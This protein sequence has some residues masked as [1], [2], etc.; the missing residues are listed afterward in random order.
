MQKETILV[1]EKIRY[2]SEW[3][4]YSIFNFPHIL[5]KQIPGCGFTEYCITNNEDVILCSPRKILLQNKYDQ[6]KDEVFLVVNEYEKEVG[7]DK[8]LTK[9]PKYRGNRFD[10]LDKPDPEK[11]KKEEGDKKSFF[12]SLTYKIS[13]YIKACRLNDRPIKILVT[14]DS[15]RIVKDIIRHQDSLENFQ[16]VVDE[17]QSIFTDSKFKSDTEMQFVSN[18]QGI[19]RVCYVSATPMIDKYLEMLEEFKDLPYY[20]LDWE[21]QDPGR[22]NKPKIITR[23]LK[24]VLTEVTPIIQTYLN[25]EFDYRY[26]KDETCKKGVRKVESKEAVFYVNSVNNITSIIKKSKL[27]PEQVNILVANTQDNVNRIR[28]T[29]GRKFDIGTVP[30]RDEPRKMFTFCTRTVYLGADFYSDNAKSYVVSDADIDTLAV[31]IS[32][33]LPQILGRQRL[34]ENPWRNE[35]MLF[36]KTL[37]PGKEVTPETFADKLKKKIKKSENLLSVFDKGNSD[38]QKYL[39]ENY[40]IVAKYMNYKDDFVA[41]NRKKVGGETIL[42]PV[43]NNLVMVSE[44]RAYEIQQVDYANR[45]TVFNELGNVSAIEDKEGL[46]EFFRGYEAQSTRLYKLKYLCEYCERVGNTSILNQIQEKRFGEYINVLG[47]DVC[48]AVWYKPAELDRRLSVFSFDTDLLDSKILS[49]F[50]VGESYPNTQIKTRLNEIYNEV[51]YKIK[52][53]ATDL[54]NYFDV[55]DCLLSI[56]SKRVHGLKILSKKGE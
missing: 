49:E 23:N 54:S 36:Y 35:A 26:V 31:D 8:D 42:T 10:W 21:A 5:N 3:E 52:A 27:T 14:Y 11:I 47:L 43:F 24:G 18:L 28:K 12:D 30:L 48:K 7:T 1:P 55:K 39:S 2:M 9:F 41:V 29:L 20:E 19:Q 32:L 15:F 45:F 4:G 6:H 51:G 40:Q 56:D 22:V 34:K 44:M 46:E 13:T 33:D 50:K 38:E 37:S 17:F 25:G 16:I 53:K